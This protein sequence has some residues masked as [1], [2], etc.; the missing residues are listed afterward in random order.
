VVSGLAPES[1]TRNTELAL[2]FCLENVVNTLN[3]QTKKVA[4]AFAH[5]S[6]SHSALTM[7]YMTQL[8]SSDVE[9]AIAT[10]LIYG[11]IEE[12]PKNPYGR[13]YSMRVF[14]R[15]Y[16]SRIEKAPPEFV[17]SLQKRYQRSGELFQEHREV[18]S[19]NRY[20]QSHYTVR[21][22]SEAIAATQLSQAFKLSER[23]DSD[24]ALNIIDEMR[25]TTPEYFE[26]YRTAAVIQLGVGDIAGAQQSYEIAID[27][28]QSQPQLFFW[29]G[30]FVMRYL[31][32]S[33][34]A[35]RLFDEA[36]KLDPKSSAVLREAARNELFVPDFEKAQA[37]L[38]QAMGLEIK[39]HKETIIIYDLQA[40][41]Y[42]RKA[43]GLAQAGDYISSIEV[44]EDLR[45]FVDKLDRTYVDIKF[46]D[47]IS[48]TRFFC[49]KNLEQRSPTRLQSRVVEL[50][51]WV[52]SFVAIP[53]E[54]LISSPVIDQG[55][56]IIIGPTPP[57]LPRTN[58]WM[59]K[60]NWQ[61]QWD[62]A[63]GDSA[64][65][66]SLAEQA[67]TWLC[68]FDFT[69][70]GWTSL[71]MVLWQANNDTFTNRAELGNLAERWLQIIDPAHPRWASLW[72]ALW[73]EAQTNPNRLSFLTAHGRAWLAGEGP[74]TDWDQVWLTL[75]NRPESRDETMKELAWLRMQSGPGSDYRIIE[76]QLRI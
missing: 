72:V 67:K 34:Q 30:G 58:L 31:N 38:D 64:R 3:D 55:Q 24:G 59:W 70:R 13:T 76:D 5:V 16:L 17:T 39:S 40:Q 32:D 37:L 65:L 56:R 35:S 45:S 66:I 57:S 36:L 43:Q 1:I 10:L 19:V 75:W 52:D 46:V 73:S 18:Y 12:D 62:D 50:L 69:R 26:V 33:A 23:G 28:D 21:S 42:I 15:A 47:H 48:K 4:T 63:Q 25:I 22:R 44:L 14:A 11:L 74:R 71:W 54:T 7:K 27:I 51:A 2:R 68:E 20:R 53:I 60:D 6:G 9:S 49:L 29:F 41:L 8:P 61:Q